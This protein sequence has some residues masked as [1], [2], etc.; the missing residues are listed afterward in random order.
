MP[1]SARLSLDMDFHKEGIEMNLKQ[2]LLADH[3]THIDL[4][5]YVEVAKG[6]SVHDTVEKMRVSRRKCAL[7]MDQGKMVGIFTERD[8][9]KKAAGHLEV[10]KQPIETQMTP[11]PETIPSDLTVIKAIQLMNTK[12]YRYMPVVNEQGFVVGTLTH[13]ALIKYIGDHFPE[14]IYN[15]PPEP[16]RIAQSRA[17]A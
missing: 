13:Y 16:G 8:I 2:N 1:Q 4:S 10:C 9:L 14:R 15:L 7:V 11:N 6:T 5:F 3:V 17:G 12:P